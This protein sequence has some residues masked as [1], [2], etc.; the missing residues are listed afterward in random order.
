MFSL[1]VEAT[2]SLQSAFDANRTS[3]PMASRPYLRDESEHFDGAKI[4]VAVRAIS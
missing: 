1:H 3:E 2:I 4:R